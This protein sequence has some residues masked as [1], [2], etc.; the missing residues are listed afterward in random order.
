MILILS[1]NGA[2]RDAG[3]RERGVFIREGSHEVERIPSPIGKEAPW[4]VIKGTLWGGEEIPKENDA[5]KII[6]GG[7]EAELSKDPL[8]TEKPSQ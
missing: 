1:K 5:S 2:I 6:W 8:Y 7:Q 4:I 3:D